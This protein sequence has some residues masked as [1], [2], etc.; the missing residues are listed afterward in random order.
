MQGLLLC[1]WTKRR[2][3]DIK[4]RVLNICYREIHRDQGVALFVQFKSNLL[5]SI[6]KNIWMGSW[7]LPL[8]RSSLKID[9][10]TPSDPK[11]DL[12]QVSLT[13]AWL[14]FLEAH[15]ENTHIFPISFLGVESFSVK[16]LCSFRFSEFGC[17]LRKGSHSC[18]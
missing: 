10:Q 1:C 13:N 9:W 15:S 14:G 2:I 18:G 3:M 17:L 8:L 16:I 11:P 7:N 5:G 6:D 4:N 12:F